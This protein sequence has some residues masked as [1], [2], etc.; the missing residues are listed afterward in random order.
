MFRGKENALML[1]WLHLPVAYHGR[2]S[3]ET[4]S[5]RKPVVRKATWMDLKMIY[6]PYGER[7]TKLVKRLL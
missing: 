4:F 6:P 7:K 3:F 1:N 5:H 2:A